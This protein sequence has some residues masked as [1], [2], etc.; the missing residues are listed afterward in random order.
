M[1]FVDDLPSELAASGLTAGRGTLAPQVVIVGGGFGGL[2]AAKEFGAKPIRVKLLDR[3]NYHL[4]QPLLYQVAMAGLHPADIAYPI[5]TIVRNQRN[6][7]VLLGEVSAIDKAAKQVILADGGLM[8]YDYLILATGSRTFYFEQDAWEEKA[9]GLKDVEDALEIRRRVLLAFELAEREA[10]DAEKRTHL[11]TFVVIGGGPTGVELAGSIAELSR[12]A[13][14]RDFRS[15]DP[16]QSRIY[17]LEG[18]PRILPS[19]A[20]ELSA[21]ALADLE[22]LGVQVKTNTKVFEVREDG[23]ML[24]GESISAG[25]VLWAAG[26]RPS[27]LGAT[28]DVDLDRTGRVKVSPDLSVPGFPEIFVVGDLSYFEQ[29]GHPLPGVAPV[30]IQGGRAAARAIIDT[31][32]GR[33]RKPFRYVDKGN[34]ATIGRAAAIAELPGNIRLHGLIAW[35]AW[36]FVHILYLIGFRSKLF[37]LLQWTWAYFMFDLGARLI[38][39]KPSRR[40]TPADRGN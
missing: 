20:E 35:I 34:M 24:E 29:D 23:V 16:G 9:P 18:G 6:V 21:S 37:V 1:P 25:T 22:R 5:R 36:L 10:S 7:Q 13:I 19:F 4:F 14:R 3:R 17:L 2:Y 11:L 15:I 30:A 32:A 40:T 33:P 28:L 27:P 12:H 26:V 38:T 31:I 8:R 39:G